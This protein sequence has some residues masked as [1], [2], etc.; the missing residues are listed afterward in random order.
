MRSFESMKSRA[1]VH[2]IL[3]A[4]ILCVAAFF[5]VKFYYAFRGADGSIIEK[6]KASLTWTIAFGAV[7]VVWFINWIAVH[8]KYTQIRRIYG[9]Y[10]GGVLGRILLIL[11]FLGYALVVAFLFLK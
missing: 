4:I 8:K 9:G 10:F 3:Q 11:E 2:F 5:Y 7:S 6:L 1:A